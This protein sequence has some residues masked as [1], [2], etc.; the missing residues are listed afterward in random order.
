VVTKKLALK[1]KNTIAQQQGGGM[2]G[3]RLT[4]NVRHRVVNRSE[5]QP[6]GAAG[7]QGIQRGGRK[8]RIKKRA[9]PLQDSPSSGAEICQC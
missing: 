4:L 3:F 5:N 7:D 1:E 8:H 6:A 2:P 9:V